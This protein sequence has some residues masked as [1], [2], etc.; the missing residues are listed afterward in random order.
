MSSNPSK[1]TATVVKVRKEEL[2][3]CCPRN[4]EE[5]WSM[6]PKVYLQFDKNGEATCPYC[7]AKYLLQD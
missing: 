3:L 5:A 2:P 6:H 4:D 1:S 7:G